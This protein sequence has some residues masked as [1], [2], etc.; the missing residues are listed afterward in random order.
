MVEKASLML[1]GRGL[2]KKGKRC[3][4]P[5]EQGVG[6]W[7]LAFQSYPCASLTQCSCESFDLPGMGASA[8]TIMAPG[9]K[10]VCHSQ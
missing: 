10:V 5:E 4:A 2:L 8:W 3:D 9:W 7:R 1:T 6:V